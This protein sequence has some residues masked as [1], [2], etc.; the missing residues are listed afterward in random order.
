MSLEKMGERTL[1]KG[2]FERTEEE[3]QGNTFT[4]SALAIGKSVKCSHFCD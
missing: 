3:V 1:Q 4:F 2:I